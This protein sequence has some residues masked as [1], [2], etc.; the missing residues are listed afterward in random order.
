MSYNKIHER[1]EYGIK[2]ISSTLIREDVF[3]QLRQKILSQ[4]FK[5][6]EKLTEKDLAS[7]LGISRTPVREALHKLEL[8]GL[9]EIYPRRFCLVKGVT[10]E[11]IH[12]IHLIRS[13]LEPVAAYYAVDNLTDDDLDDLFILLQ[14]ASSFATS[15]NIDELVKTNN[16]FHRKINEA[17]NLPRI[18]AIL[19]NMNDYIEFFRY[20]F[21]SRPELAKRTIKEHERI[22]SALQARD[23]EAVKKLVSTHLEG[24]T[25]YE[26]VVLEN[27][28]KEARQQLKSN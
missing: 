10:L 1:S 17:S 24:I 20:S 2:K 26:E 7:Q 3:N 23:K 28:K 5:P 8:E 18:I 15:N 19:E 25:E 22:L 21:M 12:E 14:K 27:M 13:Q 4:E 16:E 11:C 6:G 9:V